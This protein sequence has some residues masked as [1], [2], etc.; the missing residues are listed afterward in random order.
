MA[1]KNIKNKIVATKKT[2]QVT[3][4]MEAVSAVKMRKSQERALAS[5]SYAHAAARML[6]H[7]SVTGDRALLPYIESRP[8]GRILLVLVTSDKG[9]AGSVNS[10]VLKQAEQYIGMDACDSICIGRKA[11]EFARRQLKGKVIAEYVGVADDFTLADVEDIATKISDAFASGV[12][13]EVHVNYQTFVS[14]FEQRPT[15]QQLLP[16]KPSVLRD[17]VAGIRPKEGMFAGDESELMR[18]SDYTYEP[19]A[20]TV[21]KSLMPQLINIMIFHMLIESKACE[22]SARMIAMKNATDKTKEMIKSLTLKFNK[23][24]QAVIT[25]EVSEISGGMEAMKE[26]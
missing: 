2:G 19:D 15:S 9:L 10:A 4:A 26:V 12:Y 17:I 20:E 22:H 7:L 8:E 21:L 23:E 18:G 5:R 11:V 3:K 13:K 16:L 14:T 6:E 24:R 25:A 1:L